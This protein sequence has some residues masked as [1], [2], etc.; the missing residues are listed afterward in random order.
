[1]D[2]MGPSLA[3]KVPSGRRLHL[4]TVLMLADQM[5][6]NLE[7]M[8]SMGYIHRDIKP[9]NFLT[10]IGADANKIFIIDFGLSRK[11]LDSSRRH[12]PYVDGQGF[13][14]TLR[15]AAINAHLGIEQ[16]RRDDLEALGYVLLFFLKRKLPWQGLEGGSR[17][18]K[19]D[20]IKLTKLSTTIRELCGELPGEF[21]EYL[22]Y[23][24]S[25]GFREE[26]DYSYLKGLFRHLFLS[27][28]FGDQV[29]DWTP[30]SD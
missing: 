1:M 12:I 28:G 2:L 25:L 14:G 15:Y 7:Y 21:G 22:R 29:F 18:G 30:V 5:I 10:G 3:D 20:K 16:S 23:C 11:Y 26:P 8:H 6:S 13:E 24:R 9:E 19:N 27:E 4:K 17:E